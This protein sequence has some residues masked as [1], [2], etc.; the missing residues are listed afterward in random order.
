M[1]LRPDIIIL[2]RHA[3]EVATSMLALDCIPDRTASGRLVLLGPRD[4][5][6]LVPA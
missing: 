1:R 6:V 5:G 2:T 3:R 4:P